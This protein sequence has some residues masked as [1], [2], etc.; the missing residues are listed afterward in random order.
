MMLQQYKSFDNTAL[1]PVMLKELDGLV[2]SFASQDLFYTGISAVDAW[3]NPFG[4]K[5]Y[6]EVVWTA[7]KLPPKQEERVNHLKWDGLEQY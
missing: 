1:T 6:G 5:S 3:H 7:G 4:F 2:F